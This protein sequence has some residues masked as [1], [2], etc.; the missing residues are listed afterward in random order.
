M[1]IVDHDDDDDH[2]DGNVT[3]TIITTTNMT[4]T[5]TM[6]SSSISYSL[7]L[8]LSSVSIDKS[9]TTKS[10]LPL[11]LHLPTMNWQSLTQIYIVAFLTLN[12]N[13]LQ[14]FTV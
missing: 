10:Y 8:A 6:T 9:E 13:P 12:P 5:T 2:C 1:T 14:Y 11:S 7:V 3:T 4:I